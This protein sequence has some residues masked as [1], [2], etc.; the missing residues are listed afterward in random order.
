[1]FTRAA[2]FIFFF[3]VLLSMSGHVR[4]IRD[5][6]PN[7]EQFQRNINEI[8]NKKSIQLYYKILNEL[9][10]RPAIFVSSAG[11][12]LPGK[13][14]QLE[15]VLDYIESSYIGL[16]TPNNVYSGK[17]LS[18]YFPIKDHSSSL[19]FTIP[20]EMIDSSITH[21]LS[22]LTN[23]FKP[24]RNFKNQSNENADKCEIQP[25]EGDDKICIRDTESIVGFISRFFKSEG[26]FKIL[27]TKQPETY[28]SALLQEYGV[29]EDPEEIEGDGKVFC[30]PMGDAF[31]CHYAFT[32]KVLKVSLVTENGDKVEAVAVCHMH[33]NF[34]SILNRMLGM[35]PGSDA[36]FCHFL[37]AGHFILVQSPTI[38][39]AI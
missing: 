16:F 3:H 35:K 1:M 25:G 8:I 14:V 36:P 4:A 22:D 11:L 31:Y 29:I 18:I 7:E 15:F 33:N 12:N 17:H 24:R 34:D 10:K 38:Y 21:S 39:K 26:S 23:I 6:H 28:S 27:E 19:P 20:Q 37:P 2:Y 13:G 9:F 5:V 32:T 30:H